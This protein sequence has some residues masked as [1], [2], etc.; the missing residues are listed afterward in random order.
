MELWAGLGLN[1]YRVRSNVLECECGISGVTMSTLK[2]GVQCCVQIQLTDSSR[3]LP[4]TI[5]GD[6]AEKFLGCSSKQL[7]EQAS[8]DGHVDLSSFTTTSSSKE[9]I[10]YIKTWKQVHGKQVTVKYNVARLFD[11]LED[12]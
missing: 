4:A 8:Q 11:S 1:F 9:Y 3:E 7:M 12:D 10:I 2:E 5:F 6:N